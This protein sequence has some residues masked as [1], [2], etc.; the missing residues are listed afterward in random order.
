M[1]ITGSNKTDEKQTAE[2]NAANDDVFGA[3]LAELSAIKPTSST[4]FKPES[5]NSSFSQFASMVSSEPPPLDTVEDT[6]TDNND[7]GGFSDFPGDS[8]NKSSINTIAPSNEF[9]DFSTL[10]GE[11]SNKASIKTTA[12]SNDFG[13]FSTQQGD[14]SNKPSINTTAPSNDFGDFSTLQGESSNK[15]SIISTALSNDFGA[16]STLQGCLLYTSPSPRDKRQSRMP[17]SA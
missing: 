10:Q 12:P 6:I 1:D 7:F 11:S 2:E 15:P 13:D 4:K 17:S 3:R 14:S 16:F 8:S 9:G 5:S